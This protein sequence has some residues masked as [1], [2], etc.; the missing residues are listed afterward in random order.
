MSK[1]YGISF[2]EAERIAFAY[3]LPFYRISSLDVIDEI[4]NNILSTEGPM[5][6]EVVLDPGQSFEPKLSARS[7]PDGTMVSPSLEDMFPFLPEEEMKR[8]R[9]NYTAKGD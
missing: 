6:C 1:D 2:P 4:L 3:N 7:L 5:L 8:N 9:Y